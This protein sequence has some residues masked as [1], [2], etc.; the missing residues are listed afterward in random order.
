MLQRHYPA[1]PYLLY[2]DRQGGV[3]DRI[4]IPKAEGGSRP[5]F[6]LIP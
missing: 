5:L 1:G 3:I 6:F 2:I 4:E